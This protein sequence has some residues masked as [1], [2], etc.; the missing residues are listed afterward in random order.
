MQ[1]GVSNTSKSQPG[2]SNHGGMMTK[3]QAVNEGKRQMSQ[4]PRR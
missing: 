1:P 4:P 2:R 3:K